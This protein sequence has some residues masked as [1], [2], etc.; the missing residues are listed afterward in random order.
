MGGE[1]Y[2]GQVQTDGSMWEGWR[3]LKSVSCAGSCE[4]QHPEGSAP[5]ATFL[6]GMQCSN[7]VGKSSVCLSTLKQLHSWL[8]NYA[9]W[10]PGCLET[11][12]GKDLQS[13]I[14]RVLWKQRGGP[15]EREMLSYSDLRATVV[16]HRFPWMQIFV[17]KCL[18]SEKKKK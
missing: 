1:G 18:Q 8:D 4:E 5:P 13:S 12:F 9:G 7:A 15:W 6:L 16:L 11:R 14:F 2:K 17:P 10:W 3:C